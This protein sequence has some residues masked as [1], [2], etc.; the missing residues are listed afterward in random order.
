MHNRSRARHAL[1][2]TAAAIAAVF[3]ASPLTAHAAGPYGGTA[4]NGFSGPVAISQSTSLG[5]PTIIADSANRLFVTAPQ[6]IGNVNPAGASPLFTSLDG[7][8]T[9]GAPVRSQACTGLS[10]GDTDLAVDGGDNVFQTDL[11][12]GNSCLSISTNHGTSFAAGNPFGTHPNVGDDRPWLAWNKTSNQLYAIYDGVDAIHAANTAPLVNPLIGIQTITDNVV[13]PESALNSSSVPNTVR[14]CVCPP[15]GIAIDNSSGSSTHKGRI[16]VSYSHQDGTA[17]SY[18]DLSGTC[19]ACTATTWNGPIVIPGSGSTMSAFENEFNFDP[20]KV[21]A[22]GTIYVAWAHGMSFNTTSRLATSVQIE[23]SYST[24]GGVNWSSPRTIST[25]GGT[26]TFPTMDVVSPGVID[27]AWY[28]DP[29]HTSDPNAATGPWNL[30]FTRVSAAASN[31]PTFTISPSIAI[32]G[33]HTGCIQSGGGASCADRSLLDFFSL[34]EDSC[35]NPNVIYSGGD[36]T[37][38]VQLYF[39]KLPLTSC[40][41]GTVTP[42]VPWVPMLIGPGTAIAILGLRRRG[43]RLTVP[44]TA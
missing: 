32:Q 22:N 42:E 9:W 12:L 35:G 20:I 3:G 21:D 17:I 41:Q 33:M 11:W 30:Y 6:K 25:E 10:G 24:N 39:T 16:Y 18:A 19:P 38:D 34:A 8:A 1:F 40:S 15:G 27:V 13:I 37:T 5:E 7:G 29:A 2:V 28:G 14:A 23:Y 44:L 31:S 43:R 36:A 26:S 4:A